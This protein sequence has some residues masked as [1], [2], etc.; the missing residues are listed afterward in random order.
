MWFKIPLPKDL[1]PDLTILSIERQC[2]PTVKT[3][4]N[5]LDTDD[6]RNVRS[7][8]L[9]SKFLTYFLA[10]FRLCLIILCVNMNFPGTETNLLT[11][12]RDLFLTHFFMY[13]FFYSL[14][15]SLWG[16][17]AL[18]PIQISN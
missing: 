1:S 5:S 12:I 4:E 17:L 15:R 7:K 3:F 11:F 2:W 13:L 8:A 9:S 16:N 10:L 18:L 14:L 6:E